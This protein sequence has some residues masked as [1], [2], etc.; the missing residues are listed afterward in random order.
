MSRRTSRRAFSCLDCGLDTGKA[1]EYY[2]LH[3]EVW[4]QAHGGTY[5]FKGMLCVGCIEAPGRLG[6][7]LKPSDFI[8]AFINRDGGLGSG[9]S[10]RLRSRQE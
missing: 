7:R 6:R 9:R 8:D 5:V 10:D 4:A 2:M 3:D 1:R